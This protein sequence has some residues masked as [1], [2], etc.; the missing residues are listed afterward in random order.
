MWGQPSE[1]GL[2]YANSD[3]APYTH[4]N[5][6]SGTLH[7]PTAAARAMAK[8]LLGLPLTIIITTMPGRPG[9][10]CLDGLACHPCPW[11]VLRPVLDT[12][13]PGKFS[14]SFTNVLAVENDSD[15]IT[16]ANMALANQINTMV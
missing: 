4:W 10:G 14:F 9:M 16:N 7:E 6:F 13:R 15:R 1:V 3:A 11:P 8:C 12:S 2:Y 5:I